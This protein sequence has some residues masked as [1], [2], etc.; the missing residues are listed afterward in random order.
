[1]KSKLEYD[2]ACWEAG[3]TDGIAIIGQYGYLNPENQGLSGEQ[4]EETL[5]EGKIN[6][7]LLPMI[8]VQGECD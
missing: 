1:M 2:N 3:T 4:G 8:Q 6:V 7:N 5:L